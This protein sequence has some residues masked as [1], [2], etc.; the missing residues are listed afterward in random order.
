[1]MSDFRYEIKTSLPVIWLEKFDTKNPGRSV[2]KRTRTLI[3]VDLVEDG[4]P[5]PR[6]DPPN[7]WQFDLKKI[8]NINTHPIYIV[9]DH[10]F[11][12]WLWQSNLLFQIF[13]MWSQINFLL[14][15]RRSGSRQI[16]FEVFR[17]FWRPKEKY[18]LEI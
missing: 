2:C 14:S 3:L 5:C 15:I 12:Y 10:H 4:D 17:P 7:D 9:I 18:F 11:L 1:M 8:K 16:D 6:T 13:L